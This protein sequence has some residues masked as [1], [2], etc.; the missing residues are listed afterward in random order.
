M[1]ARTNKD[2]PNTGRP[3]KFSSPE[4]MQEKIDAYFKDA[5]SKGYPYTILDLCLFLDIDRDTL[6]MYCKSDGYE[7]FFGIAKKAK[8]RVEA[9]THRNMLN[10]TNNTA[11]AIF[12]L[13][14]NFKWKETED[15]VSNIPPIT[16]IFEQRQVKPL[17]SSEAEIE[18]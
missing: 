9:D 2:I 15:V 6:L 3:K 1:A 13:K 18:D 14:C 12:T 17:P 11:G 10:G 4:V 7:E 5:D 8:M 16:V